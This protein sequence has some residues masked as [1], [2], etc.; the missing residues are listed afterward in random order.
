MTSELWPAQI[1]FQSGTLSQVGVYGSTRTP[2]AQLDANAV[3][4]TREKKDKIHKYKCDKMTKA[5]QILCPTVHVEM[6]KHWHI[7]RCLLLLGLMIE[8]MNRGCVGPCGQTRQHI[9]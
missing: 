4:L 5:D 8:L 3:Q 7:D 2:L 6:S 9:H 1:K